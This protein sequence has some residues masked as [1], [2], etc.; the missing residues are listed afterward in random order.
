M[1]RL[2]LLDAV[3]REPGSRLADLAD[4]ANLHVNTARDHLKVLEDEG[5]ILSY[6]LTTGTRGRPPQV[7]HPV[8][9]VE[10]S[11]AA[12]R[13]AESARIHGEMLRRLNPELDRTDELGADATHQID[14]LYEHLDDSGFEPVIDET[15]LQIDLTPCHA[16]IIKR[17]HHL[18]CT[19]HERLIEQHLDQVPGPVEKREL[20]PFASKHHCTLTLVIR[21]EN[22]NENDAR[23]ITESN[24]DTSATPRPGDAAPAASDREEESAR[25][26]S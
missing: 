14:T 25:R 8:E 16:D 21:D 26:A 23:N 7:F 2:R 12:S 17:D 3:Q 20:T 24:D 6:S 18:L 5:L 11:P 9:D 4:A 10:S 1:S 15:H 19:V 13:R 22:E